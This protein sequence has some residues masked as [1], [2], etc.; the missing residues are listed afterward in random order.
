MFGK[1][2]VRVGWGETICN[3]SLRDHSEIPQATVDVVT[4]LSTNPSA[5]GKDEITLI[6]V[7]G[8]INTAMTCD[9]DVTEINADNVS[10]CCNNSSTITWKKDNTA[11]S[12]TGSPIE[13]TEPGT[14]EAE[15]TAT[16]T[17]GSETITSTCIGSETI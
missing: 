1:D 13:V 9:I 6:E 5:L 16:C 12:Q 3:M 14:Y 17:A 7:S 11:I 4:Q 10:S 8:N 2:S 15:E